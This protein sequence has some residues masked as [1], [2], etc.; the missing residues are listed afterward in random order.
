MNDIIYRTILHCGGLSFDLDPRY[1][2]MRGGWR[3]LAGGVNRVTVNIY[4]QASE[5]L[6]AHPLY[7]GVPVEKA[8]KLRSSFW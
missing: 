5:R 3:L 6:G 8:I 7:I 2:H 1:A 4:L